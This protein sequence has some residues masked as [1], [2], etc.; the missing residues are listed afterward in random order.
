MFNFVKLTVAKLL[1]SL[2]EPVGLSLYYKEPTE[3][4][5]RCDIA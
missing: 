3:F 5:S 2:T 4:K 1:M